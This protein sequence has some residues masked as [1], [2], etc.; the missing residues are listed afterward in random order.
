MI[1]ITTHRVVGR[2]TTPHKF[3]NH[4]VGDLICLIPSLESNAIAAIGVVTKSVS[5]QERIDAYDAVPSYFCV[6]GSEGFHTQFEPLDN[7]HIR[8]LER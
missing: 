2:V 5:Y 7:P 3:L 1:E 6:C 8:V 4:R